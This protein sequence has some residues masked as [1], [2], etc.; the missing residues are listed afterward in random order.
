M[1]VTYFENIWCNAV[2]INENKKNGARRVMIRENVRIRVISKKDKES[3]A[4][5]IFS[6][7]Q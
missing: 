6:L 3:V 7:T 5:Y 2:L 4:I 1:V